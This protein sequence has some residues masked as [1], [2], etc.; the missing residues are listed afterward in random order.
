MNVLTHLKQIY[1]SHFSVS[2]MGLIPDVSSI[3]S[4]LF[5]SEPTGSDEKSKDITTLGSANT[6]GAYFKKNI[7]GFDNSFDINGDQT[8]TADEVANIYRTG[9]NDKYPI[10]PRQW[11]VLKYYG[12]MVKREQDDSNTW[13]YVNRFGIIRQT[14]HTPT[15]T[16]DPT[17]GCSSDAS[18]PPLTE[19]HYKLLLENGDQ[20]FYS[21]SGAASNIMPINAH[22][23]MDGK[24]VEDSSSFLGM[25]NP[26]NGK[27]MTWENGAAPNASCL[28]R[29]DGSIITPTPTTADL[30]S[31]GIFHHGGEISN[32]YDCPFPS[33]VRQMT[34]DE[35]DRKVVSE[36]ENSAAYDDAYMT[37]KNAKDAYDIFMNDPTNDT[38]D[39]AEDVRKDKITAP[40]ILPELS[41]YYG[42]HVTV[43][44]GTD[45]ALVMNPHSDRYYIT[46]YG[47]PRKWAAKSKYG[48]W[49]SAG[50][51]WQLRPERCKGDEMNV[52]VHISQNHLTKFKNAAIGKFGAAA[53]RNMIEHE[54]CGVSGKVIENKVTNEK[55]W[56]DISG[57][58][59]LIDET[60]PDSCKSPTPTPIPVSQDSFN[61]IPGNGPMVNTCG[62]SGLSAQEFTEYN[63]KRQAVIDAAKDV[64]KLVNELTTTELT[65]IQDA[66]EDEREFI[67]NSV[68]DLVREKTTLS[69]NQANATNAIGRFE[70]GKEQTTY[71]FRIYVV[72]LIVALLVMAIAIHTMVSG[73]NTIFVYGVLLLSVLI[74][75][76]Y[77]Y[78]R[79]RRN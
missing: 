13:Y 39:A 24:F 55:A 36:K 76:F 78:V 5:D 58:K 60:S 69:T 51:A 30:E 64:A 59:H 71:A 50:S 56:V 3:V 23:G 52:V 31:S 67:E 70:T 68:V 12:K 61:A 79:S 28:L 46:D 75:L 22:C 54:P 7:E 73:E 45:G 72:W 11:P 53:L 65:I 8:I 6:Q 19:D 44:G 29:S 27:Y 18:I 10:S 17:T 16:F 38:N 32:T 63:E 49:N 1:F 35:W 14:A 2:R 74:I 33:H 66:T 57:N 26:I 42:K 4:G 47:I 9:T 15:H 21:D 41:Q 40:E 37:Y 34:A 48:R 43:F 25:V 77:M 62:V 20:N